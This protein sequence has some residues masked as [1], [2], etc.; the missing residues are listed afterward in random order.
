MHKIELVL[1]DNGDSLGVFE[2]TILPAIEDILLI[3][4][5]FYRVITRNHSLKDKIQKSILFI[6]EKIEDI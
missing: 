1:K 6:I 5:N 4:G 3:E 2:F